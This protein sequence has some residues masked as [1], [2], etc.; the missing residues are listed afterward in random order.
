MN[1]Y[2]DV[3]CQDEVKNF[4]VAKIKDKTFEPVFRDKGIV[5]GERLILISRQI[6]NQRE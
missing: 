3:L 2:F 4:G 5:L 6:P 1:K